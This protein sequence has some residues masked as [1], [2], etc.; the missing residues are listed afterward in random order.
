MIRLRDKALKCVEFT[1]QIGV[2]LGVGM[3]SRAEKDGGPIQSEETMDQGWGGG[4][5]RRSPRVE[6]LKKETETF[7]VTARNPREGQGLAG[8]GVTG[9]LTWDESEIGSL[10]GG[11]APGFVARGASTEPIEVLR[12]RRL[13]AGSSNKAPTWSVDDV[14]GLEG[15]GMSDC[16]LC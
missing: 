15:V 9:E 10:G 12:R 13:G 4:K 5:R 7:E 3:S 14:V 16:G 8:I 11:C 1:G 6:A 2:E